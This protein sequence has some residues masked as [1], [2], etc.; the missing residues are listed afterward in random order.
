MPKIVLLC[1][2][3]IVIVVAAYLTLSAN[4]GFSPRAQKS[5]IDK[6]VNQAR[7]LF[8]SRKQEGMDFSNGPCLSDALMSDWVVDIAH[9]PRLEIDD[10]S[11]NQCPAY[12]EGRAQHFVELDVNGELIRV[13]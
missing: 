9:N 1:I 5:E 4:D 2:A 3:L 6:A 12:I 8:Q 13:K 11:G 10:L 7:L